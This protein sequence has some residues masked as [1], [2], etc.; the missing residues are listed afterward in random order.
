MASQQKDRLA[1]ASQV[2]TGPAACSVVV[3]TGG[4]SAAAAAAST[5]LAHAC[6]VA[7]ILAAA[8]AVS[9]QYLASMCVLICRPYCP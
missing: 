5:V 3:P 6:L 1:V 2:L 9:A 8:V 7:T 4:V